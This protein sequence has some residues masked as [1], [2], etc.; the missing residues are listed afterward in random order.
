M[1]TIIP[2]TYPKE[3]TTMLKTILRSNN[4]DELR[5]LQAQVHSATEEAIGFGQEN[6][7]I[8]SPL[9]KKDGEDSYFT[10]AVGPTGNDDVTIDANLA[11]VDVTYGDEELFDDEEVEEE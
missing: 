10:V 11:G 7:V 3:E 4:E 8:V 9:I 1:N 5:D 6:G 2:N